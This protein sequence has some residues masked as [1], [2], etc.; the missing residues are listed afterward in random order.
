MI[1]RGFIGS[2]IV[3][4]VILLNQVQTIIFHQI[5]K[6]RD[7]NFRVSEAESL[8]FAQDEVDFI[9]YFKHRGKMMKM[10]LCV[11]PLPSC[12]FHEAANEQILAADEV[13]HAA[14][15]VTHKS[16]GGYITDGDSI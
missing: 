7:E 2:L 1:G 16:D 6:G 12:T 13:D 15:V 3:R 5:H 8:D 10:I 9:P 14:L 11:L 4:R